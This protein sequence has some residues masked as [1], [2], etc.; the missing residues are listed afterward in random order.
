MKFLSRA[1]M[2]LTS[3]K[4]LS[5]LMANVNKVIQIE[6]LRRIEEEISNKNFDNEPSR[7]NFDDYVHRGNFLESPR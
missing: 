4:G 3:K 5:K 1:Y 2:D 6:E 7:I